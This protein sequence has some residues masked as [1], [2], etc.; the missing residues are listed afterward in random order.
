MK[1]LGE[2]PGFV[3]PQVQHA[4]RTQDDAMIEYMYQRGEQPGFPPGSVPPLPG[5]I[6]ARWALGGEEILQVCK[7]KMKLRL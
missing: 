2:D 1:W 7:V 4:P 3:T 6:P 5:K